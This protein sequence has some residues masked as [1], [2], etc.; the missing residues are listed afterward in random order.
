[1]YFCDECTFANCFVVH[2]Y[3]I[4]YV[5]TVRYSVLASGAP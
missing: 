1:M 4:A 3:G 2:T 5:P